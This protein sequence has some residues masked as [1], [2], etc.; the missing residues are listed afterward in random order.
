MLQICLQ[1]KNKG[2]KL[3][4]VFTNILLELVSYSKPSA[5]RQIQDS[6][7][8]RLRQTNNLPTQNAYAVPE[9]S[10]FE[11]S[12]NIIDFSGSVESDVS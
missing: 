6:S 4:S 10:S 11:L 1:A 12:S 9:L 5:S 3:I 2:S 8:E 7:N